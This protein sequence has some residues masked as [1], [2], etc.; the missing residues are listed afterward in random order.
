VLMLSPHATS[1]PVTS[2]DQ[3]MRPGKIRY[4][5]G[6]KRGNLT[7]FLTEVFT[8]NSPH[9]SNP[10]HGGVAEIPGPVGA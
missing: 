8:L 10:G 9:P 7:T 1:C 3:L 4:F 6:F 2:L 5:Q